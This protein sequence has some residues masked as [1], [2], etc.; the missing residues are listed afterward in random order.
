MEFQP[1]PTTIPYTKYIYAARKGLQCFIFECWS[2]FIIIFC[3]EIVD[4]NCTNDGELVKIDIDPTHSFLY[5]EKEVSFFF[6]LNK[7]K[8]KLFFFSLS[9]DLMCM[10]G[11]CVTYLYVIW[12]W[13]DYLCY[14][15][16]CIIEYMMYVVNK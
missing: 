2:V 1:C 10:V 11:V 12:L 13:C 3:W 8:L 7:S 15:C 14:V 5:G 9:C 6:F 4:R 16:M